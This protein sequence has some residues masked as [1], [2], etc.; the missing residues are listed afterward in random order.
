MGMDRRLFM[1]LVAAGASAAWVAEATEAQAHASRHPTIFELPP[2]TTKRFAWTIDDGVS[3][4][5]I[6][7]YT[8]YALNDP[9]LKY[10]YFVTSSYPSWK[11]NRSALTELIGRGQVQL[12]NH[13][14][15]HPDLRALTSHG[16]Q[17]ALMDCH[18]FL[19]DTF[20]VNA[21]P[22]WRPPYGYYNTRVLQAAADIGYT[23]P[24]MWY[25]TLATDS[26]NLTRSRLHT[27][28]YRWIRDGTV[29]IDHANNMTAANNF[30]V[31]RTAITKRG[32]AMVTLRE[33]FPGY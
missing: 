32:L 23:A 10:N 22:F 21:M 6:A 2:S 12:A 14:R 26:A 1:A 13:T 28:A 33:A 5:S 8:A 29:L 25:G 16:I 20:G 27:L 30:D 11:R 7:A 18:K 19:E 15:T 4:G 3:A 17:H 9:S 31:L 24:T